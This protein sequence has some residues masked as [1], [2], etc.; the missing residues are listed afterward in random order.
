M[1]FNLSCTLESPWEL[2]KEIPMSISH[3]QESKSIS[4]V[5]WP[6]CLHTHT[7][8]CV[9][10]C[11]YVYMCVPQ[12]ISVGSQRTIVDSFKL[13][14][15]CLVVAPTMELF[16]ANS[17]SGR[18]DQAE[19]KRSKLQEGKGTIYRIIFLKSEG[20]RESGAH[21]QYCPS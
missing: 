21:I 14:N 5:M 1:V 6:R 20:V 3:P 17:N 9:F 10:V 11:V 8:K 18:N 16:L 15:K 4:L 7:Y 12:L 19:S 2:K 13:V